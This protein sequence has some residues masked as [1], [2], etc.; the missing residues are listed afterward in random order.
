[1][2]YFCNFK[3]DPKENRPID[4][5]LPNPFTLVEAQQ[6]NMPWIRRESASEHG[7]RGRER[8]KERER[9]RVN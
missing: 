3:T 4:E 5:N 1:L 9:E 7:K 6:S 2:G 8:K